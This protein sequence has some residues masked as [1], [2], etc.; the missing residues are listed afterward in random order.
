MSHTWK[1][2]LYENIGISYE[3]PT[4]AGLKP[5]NKQK[6]RT[7]L[8]NRAGVLPWIAHLAMTHFYGGHIEPNIIVLYSHLVYVEYTVLISTRA[9]HILE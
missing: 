5:T 3:P 9:K 4:E 1:F 7:V 8:V 6:K 2:R